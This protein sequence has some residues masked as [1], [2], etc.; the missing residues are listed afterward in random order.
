VSK[1]EKTLFQVLRGTADANIGFD[2]LR[3]PP[4]RLGFDERTRG[5]H[6]IF[7]RPGIEEKVNLQRDGS[8]AKPYQARQ[9]RQVV[10]KH[11]L[12]QGI[13]ES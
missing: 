1:P 3:R 4:I 10:L 11:S 6:H 8:H 13:R 9:A 7:R 5:S 2:D 12:A